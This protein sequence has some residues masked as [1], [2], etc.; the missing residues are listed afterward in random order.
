VPSREENPAPFVLGRGRLDG[1]GLL[2][3]QVPSALHVARVEAKLPFAQL[4]KLKKQGLPQIRM[5]AVRV[6]LRLESLDAPTGRELG[7]GFCLG[8]RIF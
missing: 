3:K 2:G 5:G 8:D 4:V 7:F 1:Q 6:E